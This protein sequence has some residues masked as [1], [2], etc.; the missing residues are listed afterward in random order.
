MWHS[1]YA[2]IRGERKRQYR[3]DD[4]LKITFG[5]RARRDAKEIAVAAVSYV[6]L[7]FRVKYFFLPRLIELSLESRSR[8]PTLQNRSFIAI[9][10]SDR[11]Y[12]TALSHRLQL[13]VIGKLP[14]LSWLSCVVT[15]SSLSLSLSLSLSFW[16]PTPTSSQSV[17]QPRWRF[18]R[19][20]PVV[21]ARYGTNS[22]FAVVDVCMHYSYRD[23]SAR[24]I[25]L[26]RVRARWFSTR[27]RKRQGLHRSVAPRSFVTRHEISLWLSLVKRKWF[28]FSSIDFWSRSS[29]VAMVCQR[30][31]WSL[32]HL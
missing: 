8:S 11:R 17:T 6:P 24:A 3:G 1:I 5:E 9:P 30:V 20:W 26:S 27:S 2:E 19:W 16:H 7:F 29:I 25:G 14:S 21:A 23:I 4:R 15:P 32:Q 18:R 31:G 22:T 10:A 13:R 12:T 28:S